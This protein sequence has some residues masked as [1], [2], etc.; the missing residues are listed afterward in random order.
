MHSVRGRIDRPSETHQMANDEPVI[1]VLQALLQAEVGKRD[2]TPTVIGEKLDW[3]V[4]AGPQLGF[5]ADGS[6]D[7]RSSTR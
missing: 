3:L 1:K 5:E 4:T 2:I 6:T 7:R